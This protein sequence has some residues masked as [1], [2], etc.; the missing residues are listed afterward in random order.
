MRTDPQSVHDAQ[1]RDFYLALSRAWGPQHWWPARSRF[2]VI[3]GAFLTQN[4]SWTWGDG[5]REMALP[6]VA[7]ARAKSSRRISGLL[8]I[9]AHA[10]LR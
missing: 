6:K 9:S 7:P 5:I 4:T 8:I 3:A 1:L 2:E 10:I